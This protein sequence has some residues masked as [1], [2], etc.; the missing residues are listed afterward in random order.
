[1]SC[2]GGQLAS[3]TSTPRERGEAYRKLSRDCL[4]RHVWP[5]LSVR[6]F[7]DPIAG[8]ENVKSDLGL[9]LFG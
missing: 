9:R 2:E 7:E 5:L 4:C 8:N 3:G 1:M 6:H